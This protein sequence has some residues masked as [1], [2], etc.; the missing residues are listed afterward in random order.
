MQDII[1]ALTIVPLAAIAISRVFQQWKAKVLPKTYHEVEIKPFDCAFC[2]SFWLNAFYYHQGTIF[3]MALV[4]FASMIIA[5]LID[6][7]L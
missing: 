6:T 3:E 1:T 5:S 4:W 2:L 7:R